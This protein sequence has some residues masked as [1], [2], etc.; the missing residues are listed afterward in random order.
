MLPAELLLPVGLSLLRLQTDHLKRA[1]R[2]V[3]ARCGAQHELSVWGS[4]VGESNKRTPAHMCKRV[5]G[6]SV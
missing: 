1:R 4:S 2:L 5:V 6:V 3:S